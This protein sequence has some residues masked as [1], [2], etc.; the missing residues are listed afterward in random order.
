MTQ[1]RADDAGLGTVPPRAPLVLTALIL[2][3]L[4]CNINLAAANVA[5][6]DVGDA[7]GATQTALNLVAV[8]CELG[9]EITVQYHEALADR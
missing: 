1:T 5:L 8:G 2:A 9:L 4:V 3:A 7:F 6:P